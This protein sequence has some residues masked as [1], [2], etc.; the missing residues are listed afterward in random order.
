MDDD[1]YNNLIS[2]LWELTFDP[3]SYI[4]Q[5]KQKSKPDQSRGI[6]NIL[7]YAGT[8]N[9]V[10]GIENNDIKFCDYCRKQLH[11]DNYTPSHWNKI[12]YCCESCSATARNQNDIK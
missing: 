4:T 10:S 1:T 2:N 9:G 12:K 3:E 6:R 5:D 8:I 7:R 11:K